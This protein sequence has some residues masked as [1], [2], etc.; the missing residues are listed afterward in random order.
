MHCVIETEVFHSD[1]KRI[2]LSRNE[3][4]EILQRLAHEPTNGDLIPGTGGARKMRFKK[5]HS[6]KSGGYRIVWYYAAEDVPVFALAIFDKGEK[7]NL[8]QAEKNQLRKELSGIADDYRRQVSEKVAD[9]RR[10]AS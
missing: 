10:K 1:A 4:M 8:S 2:G 6:G 7:I 9:L 5:P 3:E